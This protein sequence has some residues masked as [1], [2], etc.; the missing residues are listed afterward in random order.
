VNDAALVINENIANF[1]SLGKVP[2]GS[3]YIVF[4]NQLGPWVYAC[5]DT[6]SENM[7]PNAVRWNPNLQVG[8]QQ[9]SQQRGVPWGSK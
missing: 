4:G 1:T 7:M 9:A 6:I 5:N 8:R 3:M 2:C